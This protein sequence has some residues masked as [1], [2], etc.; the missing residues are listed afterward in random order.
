MTNLWVALVPQQLGKMKFSTVFGL[1]HSFRAFP[2]LYYLRILTDVAKAPSYQVIINVHFF[3][4][5]SGPLM[6]R[7]SIEIVFNE[8]FN[9]YMETSHPPEKQKT[10]RGEAD[11]FSLL[12]FGLTGQPDPNLYPKKSF[13]AAPTR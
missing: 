12:G 13:P 7:T 3:P 6:S 2:L 9:P 11:I 5:I 1:R 4:Q 10:K 8:K